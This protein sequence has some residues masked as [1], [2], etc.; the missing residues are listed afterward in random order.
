CGVSFDLALVSPRSSRLCGEIISNHSVN[1]SGFFLPIF[2]SQIFLS[3]GSIR[4]SASCDLGLEVFS[5]LGF[6]A[7]DFSGAWWPAR[8][9]TREDFRSLSELGFLWSLVACS[10]FIGVGA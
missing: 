7:W 4:R 1:S 9:S 10:R 5:V 6:G 2:L 8:D 3:A